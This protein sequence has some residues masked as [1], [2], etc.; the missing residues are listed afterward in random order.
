[1]KLEFEECPLLG[2]SG[3]ETPK[4]QPLIQE[5]VNKL[6]K[7]GVVVES[8]HE[9]LKY[10]SPIFLKEK[11][12]G[13]QRLVLNLKSLN[14]Y[15]EYKPLKMQT[16]QTIL[17]IVQPHCYMATI[18]LKDAYYS[19]KFGGD[20]TRYLKFPCNSTFLKFVFVLISL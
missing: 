11:T 14:K 12:V 2:C 20:Y 6:L 17:T 19:V 9:A 4:N 5:K 15:L 16:L 3:F 7:K 1:M 8:E 18:D 10:I 13:T